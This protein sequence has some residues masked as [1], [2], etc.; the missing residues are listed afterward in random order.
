MKRHS[1]LRLGMSSSAQGGAASSERYLEVLQPKVAQ[2]APLHGR[3][4]GGQARHR[5]LKVALRLLQVAF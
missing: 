1:S 4:D 5:A 3:A 2:V